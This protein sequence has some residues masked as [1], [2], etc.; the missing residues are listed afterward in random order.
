MQR[1]SEVEDLLVIKVEVV[2][3]IAGIAIPIEVL[4]LLDVQSQIGLMMLIAAL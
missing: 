4:P 2:R 3:S 1:R